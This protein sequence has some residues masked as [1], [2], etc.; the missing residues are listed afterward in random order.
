MQVDVVIGAVESARAQLALAEK[1]RTMNVRL[2]NDKFISQNA[3]DNAESSFNVAR[4]SL[5]SAEAQVQ[6]A[7]NALL[8]ADVAVNR[9][10]LQ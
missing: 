9:R 8:D 3:F 7:Q 5:K 4:G 6:L 2:L 1:T 10:H